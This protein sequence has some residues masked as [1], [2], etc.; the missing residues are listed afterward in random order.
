MK[1]SKNK[2]ITALTVAFLS[3]LPVYASE[4]I[5]GH[6]EGSINVMGNDLPIFVDI[7]SVND[8]INAKIDIPQQGAKN[9]ELTNIEYKKPNIHLELATP[10]G[11]AKLNGKVNENKITGDFEQNG[12]KG[13][14][15]LEK[16]TAIQGE[17]PPYREEEV[18]FKNGDVTIAGTLTLPQNKGNYPAIVMITGSGPQN[19]DEDI[20]GFPI[21][22]VIADH[23]TRKGIAVLRCDDRGIGGSN[24]GNILNATTA[25][26]ATDTNASV[27]FLLNHPEINKNKS[28]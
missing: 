7:T 4:K 23:L 20:F 18:S 16:K 3:S 1:N 12:Y 28:K 25:D 9:L 10:S 27:N 2:I 14:F 17:K 19:R 5:D 26:Y 13:T 24:G 21:F 11:N 22:K 8:K 6:W 15:N